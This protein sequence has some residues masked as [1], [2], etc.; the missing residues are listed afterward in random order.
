MSR[1]SLLLTLRPLTF[2]RPEMNRSINSVLFP[3]LLL[4]SCLSSFLSH[5]VRE[6]LP[7]MSWQ[8]GFGVLA[9]IYLVFLIVAF[10]ERVR[11]C[12]AGAANSVNGRV[13]TLLLLTS[14]ISSYLTH[15]I[16]NGVPL[17][18]WSY[19]FAAVAL[20]Y[21]A[22]LLVAFQRFVRQPL[23]STQP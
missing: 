18:S 14:C 17:L 22:V 21:L 20:V 8:H 4:T 3:L 1:D 23:Q 10:H 13:F 9:V 5:V 7:L 11:Q 12:F 15:C 16:S 19:G 2:N 6:H